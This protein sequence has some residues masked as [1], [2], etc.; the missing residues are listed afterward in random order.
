[1]CRIYHRAGVVKTFIKPEYSSVFFIQALPNE[2]HTLVSHEQQSKEW[3]FKRNWLTNL[4]KKFKNTFLSEDLIRLHQGEHCSHP[5]PPDITS[6]T[7]KMKRFSLFRLILM[8]N[9]S[10][11]AKVSCPNF[12]NSRLFS[13]H[14]RESK[15]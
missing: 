3:V 4:G 13:N 10:Y 14:T 15:L 11:L 9:K 7:D 12:E 5:T 2:L 1:V 8:R 6:L